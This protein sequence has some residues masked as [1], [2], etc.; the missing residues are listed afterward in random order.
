MR[1]PCRKKSETTAYAACCEPFHKGVRPAPTAEALMRSRYSAFAMRN[2]AYLRATWHPSTRKES[3]IFNQGEE[4][5]GLQIGATTSDGDTATV[6]FTARSRIG[7]RTH[8]LSEVS[9][10]RREFGRWYYVDGVVG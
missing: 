9:R 3:I 5:I 2:A 4:W 8:I 7:G 1:C 10:F 6:F